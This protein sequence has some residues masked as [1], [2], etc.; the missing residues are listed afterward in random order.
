M[1][2][3]SSEG[4]RELAPSSSAK[5]PNWHKNTLMNAQEQEQAPRSTVRESRPLTKFSNFLTLMCSLCRVIDSMSSSK[6][7]ATNQQGLRNAN[8]HDD[9]SDSVPGSEGE[10]VTNG[11]QRSTFLAKRDC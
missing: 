11:S 8:L 3:K 1:G 10:L 5:R 4:K 6:Q 9:V 2:N 7:G